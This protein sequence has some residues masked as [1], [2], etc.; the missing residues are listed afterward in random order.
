VARYRFSRALRL[1]GEFGVGGVRRAG[2]PDLYQ[3]TADGF[4][5]TDRHSYWERRAGAEL[6]V[7]PARAH[8]I[9]AQYAYRLR[10]YV[11]DPAFDAVARPNHLTPFDHDR[12]ALDLDYHYSRGAVR[13]GVGAEA[14]VKQSFFVF[15][16]DAHT[17]STHAGPRGPP[18]NPLQELRGVSPRVDFQLELWKESVEM[19]VS[20]AHEFQ[21]DAYRGYY[22]FSGPRPGLAVHVRPLPALELGAAAELSWRRYGEGSY[23]VG[24]GHPPLDSG[25]RRYDHRL[26]LTFGARLGLTSALALTLDAGYRVRDTNFP[27]YEPAVFPTSQVYDIDWDYWDMRVAAGLQAAFAWP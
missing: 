13:A 3:P 18:P 11:A 17:G 26:E 1:G 4:A 22:S 23:R 2:W 12:H 24:L 10:D 21:D 8:W 27:D 5:P 20:Y 19:E 15:A 6:T 25:D 7:H 14:F 9:R 16:R